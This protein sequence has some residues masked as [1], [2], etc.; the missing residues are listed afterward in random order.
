M[1]AEGFLRYGHVAAAR[2]LLVA[3]VEAAVQMPHHRLP[4]LFAG[5]PRRRDEAPLAY[6][7]ANVPQ[8]WAASATV[9]ACELLGQMS[10]LQR[11]LLAKRAGAGPGDDAVPVA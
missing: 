7:D 1:T 2:R 8:A 6:P 4:E 3:L 9:R 5:S 10:G 11:G